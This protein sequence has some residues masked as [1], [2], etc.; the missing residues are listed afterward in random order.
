MTEIPGSMNRIKPLAMVAAAL[1]LYGCQT[2]AG[3]KRFEFREDKSGH[4]I[5]LDAD[6][7][8]AVV[9]ESEG[10]RVLFAPY[11]LST[12]TILPSDE[13]AKVAGNAGCNP[14]AQTFSGRLYN[15]TGKVLRTVGV[16]VTHKK[17]FP[18][19]EV[20]WTREFTIRDLYIRP[21]EATPFTIPIVAAEST[22]CSWTL[23]YAY[24]T[25]WNPDATWID[26]VTH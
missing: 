13:F 4:L 26:K 25:P 8:E 12:L 20:I 5:R 18:E 11:D 14:D 19:D 6:S 3:G 15:G 24:A 2:K 9:A 17:F 21:M 10:S 23:K 7:G 16:V 1:F 22:K